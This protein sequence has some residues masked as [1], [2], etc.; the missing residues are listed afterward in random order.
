METSINVQGV[1]LM[2]RSPYAGSTSG[3]SDEVIF[4]DGTFVDGSTA[5]MSADGP[6]RE[7]YVIY[8]QGGTHW[9][10]WAI[11]LTRILCSLT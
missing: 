4:A 2:H 9:T 3:Y 5:E 1:I 10:Q 6:L 7:P 8:C 11:S